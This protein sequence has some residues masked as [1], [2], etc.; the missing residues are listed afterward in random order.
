MIVE[1]IQHGCT[2][3]RQIAE[4][5]RIDYRSVNAIIHSLERQ[6]RVS[7]EDY[8]IRRGLQQFRVVR[9]DRVPVSE[10]DLIEH[11][12]SR[13]RANAAAWHCLLHLG[14]SRP[15]KGVEITDDA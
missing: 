12:R 6:G 3:L 7:A 14:A 8:D 4:R 1:A 15:E 13:R 9:A 5:T 10:R 11:P 2:T